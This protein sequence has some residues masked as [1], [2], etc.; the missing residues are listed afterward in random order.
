MFPA[1]LT[2][3]GNLKEEFLLKAPLIIVNHFY[4]AV[5]GRSP[6]LYVIIY[7]LEKFV[8]TQVIFI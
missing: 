6:F 5:L 7:L 2:F 8:S 1:N 3:Y 4:L